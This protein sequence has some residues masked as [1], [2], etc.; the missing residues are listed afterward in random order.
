K[1]GNGFVF[2]IT[3]GE[4][5][6]ETILKSEKIFNDK[7]DWQILMQNAFDCN[8]SWDKSVLEYADMYAATA[9]KKRYELV[10]AG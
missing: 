10:F 4:N 8:F 6:I 1:K 2:N 5:F 3:Y 7:A 9:G